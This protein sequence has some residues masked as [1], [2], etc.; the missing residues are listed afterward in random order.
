MTVIDP[1]YLHRQVTVFTFVVAIYILCN[2]EA[3]AVI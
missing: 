3:D 1:N 2:Y